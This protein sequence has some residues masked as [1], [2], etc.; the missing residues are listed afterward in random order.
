MRM[1]H[2]HWEDAEEEGSRDADNKSM[3]E[4]ET[5]IPEDKAEEKVNDDDPGENDRKHFIKEDGSKNDFRGHS[6]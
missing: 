4:V 2:K 1:M 3:L 5:E 6:R